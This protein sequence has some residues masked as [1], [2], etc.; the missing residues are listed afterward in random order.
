MSTY[1][2]KAVQPLVAKMHLAKSE[3]ELI[4]NFT[5]LKALMTSMLESEEI[6]AATITT[7]FYALLEMAKVQSIAIVRIKSQ[8]E[9]MEKHIEK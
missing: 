6:E 9:K 3:D 2:E 7:C 5:E 8:I 4:Q 1:Y